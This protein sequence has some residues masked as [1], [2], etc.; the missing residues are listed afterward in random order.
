MALSFRT[1][2]VPSL[3]WEAR[4]A[5]EPYPDESAG[6][7]P[8]VSGGIGTPD[9]VRSIAVAASPL[10]L[11]LTLAGYEVDAVG[12]SVAGADRDPVDAQLFL[13]LGTMA[14]SELA[15]T[16]TDSIGLAWPTRADSP[17]VKSADAVLAFRVQ[18]RY[19]FRP[20]GLTGPVGSRLSMPLP[21]TFTAVDSGDAAGG[22]E[23][24][25]HFGF[26]EADWGWLT[27]GLFAPEPTAYAAQALPA[28]TV[29][30]LASLLPILAE[31]LAGGLAAAWPAGEP[32]PSPE[33]LPGLLRLYHPDGWHF[34]LGPDAF[35]QQLYG[36]VGR[37]IFDALA[38][39]GRIDRQEFFELEQ[40][41]VVP[42]PRSFLLRLEERFE[43][44]PL[45]HWHGTAAGKSS[46]GVVA[47]NLRDSAV[48]AHEASHF[49]IRP[50]PEGIESVSTLSYAA[51]LM[52]LHMLGVADVLGREDLETPP[53]TP[54]SAEIDGT[55]FYE[56]RDRD[57]PT[58][59]SP[60]ANPG[61]DE[62]GI[63]ADTLQI[64]IAGSLVRG[65]W[66]VHD[67]STATLRATAQHDIV[68]VLTDRATCRYVGA[69]VAT[70]G[71]L[72]TVA[73][74][75]A[76]IAADPIDWSFASDAAVTGIEIFVR[77]ATLDGDLET[78]LE[79]HDYA[80]GSDMPFAS[81]TFV[82]IH[83][84]A[85]VSDD[86]ID[87]ISDPA[88]RDLYEEL[89][90]RPL[91]SS[92]VDEVFGWALTL[93]ADIEGFF[94]AT[95]PSDR[96]DPDAATLVESTFADLV[97]P[98]FINVNTVS[99]QFLIVQRLLHARLAEDTWAHGGR[100]QPYT[101][102][103]LELCGWNRSRTVTLQGVFAIVF[104]PNPNPGPDTDSSWVP[105][106]IYRYSWTMEPV[107][108]LGVGLPPPARGI[109]AGMAAWESMRVVAERRAFAL[110]APWEPVWFQDYDVYMAAWE[111]GLGLV[112]L[113]GGVWGSGV[114]W[115]LH[116]PGE[117]I[118]DQEFF[119]G[120][121]VGLGASVAAT[122]G[123]LGQYLQKPSNWKWLFQHR[124]RTVGAEVVLFGELN[125]DTP[126]L[127]TFSYGF[128]GPIGFGEIAG[129][130]IGLAGSIK[131][132][133]AMQRR[134]GQDLTQL[135]SE[136]EDALAEMSFQVRIDVPAGTRF[137][138]T[139][140]HEVDDAMRDVL[141]EFCV[142]HL[143][144]L[145]QVHA[146]LEVVGHADSQD[147]AA[148]NVGLSL[149]RATSFYQALQDILGPHFFLSEER[150]FIGGRGELEH[151]QQLTYELAYQ[152]LGFGPHPGSPP[153]ELPD[154]SVPD[155][156]YRRVDVTLD[157]L[158]VVSLVSA[159]EGAGGTP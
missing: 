39:S 67:R 106:F 37:A 155:P 99:D 65:F 158:H 142:E 101:E 13:H 16:F 42:R 43:P 85:W 84:R 126:A 157:G 2:L 47:T 12:V 141:R 145:R 136:L 98:H 1:F 59:P 70:G 108:G 58:Q 18:P 96:T 73:T 7:G 134:P 105:D 92:E 28:G 27:L 104:P 71:V 46:A 62:T 23:W 87:A 124:G 133:F 143:D 90:R 63:D 112:T 109:F 91:H 77:Q 135:R 119:D 74:L 25:A 69:R 80:P 138:E 110:A 107:G 81:R 151:Q 121:F 130:S 30:A 97:V 156:E 53:E 41:W 6:S 111:P 32:A 144:T 52:H 51:A 72:P 93:E 153:V 24:T 118:Y 125:W 20:T 115:V 139:G 31:D 88:S 76:A 86:R 78:V 3:L 66:Q 137:F 17:S 131:L 61:P 102:W 149:D 8:W 35:Q 54:E 100:T 22:W 147:T 38:A 95:T 122:L 10:I 140:Q 82:R 114:G 9:Q 117:P 45:V 83:G 14:F 56:Q 89:Q 146:T 79:V 48:R 11:G 55:G 120:A 150:T 148:S 113:H 34:P 49:G 50:H 5:P 4:L 21:A 64:N 60:A 33:D 44:S 57:D 132:G 123:V 19:R 94:Q 128:L 116:Y 154:P 152:E 103:L 29:Q 75:N 40:L 159:L 36:A 15:G 68:A 26:T 129:F 127:P